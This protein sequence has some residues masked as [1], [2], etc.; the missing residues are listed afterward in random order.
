MNHTNTQLSR[1]QI[2]GMMVLGI[3]VWA[4]VVGVIWAILKDVR[5]GVIVAVAGAVGTKVLIK[6][7]TYIKE[8]T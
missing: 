5:D 4:I 6:W 1:T 7:L 8:G 3:C 2:C